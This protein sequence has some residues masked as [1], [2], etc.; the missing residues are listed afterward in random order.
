MTKTE[1]DLKK[2]QQQQ[3][4][5][6]KIFGNEAILDRSFQKVKL[7]ELEKI[8]RRNKGTS[9]PVEKA[10]LQ[11]L[12]AGNKSIERQLYPRFR[13]RLLRRLA[14]AVRRVI[15]GK[16]KRPARPKEASANP[17][18]KNWMEQHVHRTNGMNRTDKKNERKAATKSIPKAPRVRVPESEGNAIRMSR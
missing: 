8:Y 9:D 6:Q 14:A 7:K 18:A 10:T 1:T 17:A 15:L 13:Q 5:F 12:K 16:P 2:W 4:R 3:A 11:W